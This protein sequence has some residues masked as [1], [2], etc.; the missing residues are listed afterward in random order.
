MAWHSGNALRRTMKPVFIVGIPQGHAL[1]SDL[2]LAH[3]A[4]PIRRA[5]QACSIILY[6]TPTTL[7]E[8]GSCSRA[9]S[10]RNVVFTSTHDADDRHTA[11]GGPEGDDQGAGR[12]GA[13]CFGHAIDITGVHLDEGVEGGGQAL[14]Q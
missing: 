12:R 5:A 3:G 7:I 2:T 8:D 14:V 6:G 1:N 4:A 10:N 11:E 13:G 9:A